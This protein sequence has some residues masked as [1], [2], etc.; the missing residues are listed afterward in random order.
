MMVGILLLMR[1][2]VIF[3]NNQAICAKNPLSLPIIP[4][5]AIKV[6]ERTKDGVDY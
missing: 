3:G 2:L 6:R 1:S 4:N 5:P